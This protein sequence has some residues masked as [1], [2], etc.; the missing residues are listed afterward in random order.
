MR[1]M[2]NLKS[3]ACELTR[4]ELRFAVK[5]ICR[6][7]PTGIKDFLQFNLQV[8]NTEMLGHSSLYFSTT[9]STSLEVLIKIHLCFIANKSFL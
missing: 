8:Q 4:R 9:H 3:N 6:I 5:E 7:G 1:I 2:S